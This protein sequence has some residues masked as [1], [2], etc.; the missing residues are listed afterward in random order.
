MSFNGVQ[1]KSSAVRMEKNGDPSE[2]TY[3]SWVR[4]NKWLSL[5][6]RAHP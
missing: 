4:E 1:K 3:A 2:L 5:E 6:K